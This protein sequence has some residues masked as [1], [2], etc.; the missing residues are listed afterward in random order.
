MTTAK[1]LLLAAGALVLVVAACL[2][3]GALQPVEHVASS[4][5]DLA[6]EREAVWAALADF[7]SWPQWNGAADAVRRGADREGKAVWVV[8]SE[9]GDMPS[10]VETNDPPAK[11]V[12]RIPAD[13]DLGFT[14]SWTYALEERP[15]GGTRVTVTEHGA[16][17]SALFRFF[18]VFTGYHGTQQ[19]F[20][21]D[22]AARF[23]EDVEPVPVE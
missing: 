20:L 21:R 4:R 13:A 22:L 15:S 3:V 7:E 8:S 12:T 19:E 18:L 14:G 11:L 17:E 5:V 6:A 16:V 10:I 1:K 2:A 9:W 23:G